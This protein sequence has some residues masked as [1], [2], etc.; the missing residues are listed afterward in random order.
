[1]EA[2]AESIITMKSIELW[3]GA[4]AAK[5]PTAFRDISDLVP[6]PDN[7]EIY[8][9][10]S[11]PE[12]TGNLNCGQVFFEILEQ[13]DLEIVEAVN[14][15]FGDLAECNKSDLKEVK[16]AEKLDDLDG[17]DQKLVKTYGDSLEAATL[18][19]M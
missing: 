18:V 8:Q 17:L 9:D 7:Q 11:K 16:K 1:M 4:M 10:M 3:G 5:V 12:Q 19:G 15:C 13:Q 6:V 14:Y 2:S